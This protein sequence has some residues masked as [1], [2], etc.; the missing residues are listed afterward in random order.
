MRRFA[1][2]AALLLAGSMFAFAQSSPP[3]DT[4]GADHNTQ[5]PGNV[6][7]SDAQQNQRSTNTKGTT[8]GNEQQSS[9][10]GQSIHSTTAA[11]STS[12]AEGQQGKT[13]ATAARRRSHNQTQS[14]YDSTKTGSSAG[15]TPHASKRRTR[16]KK[17]TQQA[18]GPRQ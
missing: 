1:L 9:Y 3:S 5:R 10:A 15:K 14:A 2:I 6:S 8:S 17:T 11:Q 7:R 16:R 4:L 13:A 12:G 18:S